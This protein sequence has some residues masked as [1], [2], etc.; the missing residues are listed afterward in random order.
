M[1]RI[2]CLLLLFAMLLTAACGAKSPMAVAEEYVGEDVSKLIEE[3][4]EPLDRVYQSSCAVAGAK[5]GFLDYEGF[6]VVTMRT[7]EGEIIQRVDP[8]E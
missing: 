8:S 6:T 3:I 2:C 1:K 7:E 4:G 5:D